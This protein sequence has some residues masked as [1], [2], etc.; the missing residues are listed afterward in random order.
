[1]SN[2]QNLA[3]NVKCLRETK[4]FSQEKL[5]RLADVAN[6]TIIKI[7]AGKNQ[8]PTLDTLKMIF[9]QILIELK[10]LTTRPIFIIAF[11]SLVL[12]GMGLTYF[13][14]GD[15]VPTDGPGRLAAP[16]ASGYWTAWS[17]LLRVAL[18]VFLLIPVFIGFIAGASLAEDRHSGYW[19]F[20]LIRVNS[21]MTWVSGKIAGIFAASFTG[22]SLSFFLLALFSFL[23]YPS[24]PLDAGI[25]RFNQEFFSDSPYLYLG[26]VAVIL[27]LGA[28]AMAGIACLASIWIKNPY[29]VGAFPIGFIL[30]SLVLNSLTQLQ[31]FDLFGLLSFQ[32]VGSSLKNIALS[33]LAYIVVCYGGTIIFFGREN[34]FNNKKG[35]LR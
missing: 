18:A 6:N 35:I 2:N 7:E 23:L 15:G 17:A 22:T 26:L 3:K 12:F 9:R 25:V 13:T 29:A 28:G 24:A 5:A 32:V 21:R 20:A 19:Q 10:R 31:I 14:I 11:T 16:D 30:F 27:G 1:M 33:W 4:G 8:N 34:I